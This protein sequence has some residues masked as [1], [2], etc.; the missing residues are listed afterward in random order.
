MMNPRTLSESYF[1]YP[2]WFSSHIWQSLNVLDCV[3]SMDFD[4][5][6]YWNNI[7]RMPSLLFPRLKKPN[8]KGERKKGWK[9]KSCFLFATT[10]IG[11]KEIFVRAALEAVDDDRLIPSDS[12][13]SHL[14]VITNLFVWQL[15]VY[16]GA[17]ARVHT[18]THTHN[19]SRED[20]SD[21]YIFLYSNLI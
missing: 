6:V 3:S 9:N 20:R 18:H 11:N 7:T 4:G 12:N 15:T 13:W 17:R 14:S 10:N 19:E 21:S 1:R 8:E 16:Q 2:E 5:S